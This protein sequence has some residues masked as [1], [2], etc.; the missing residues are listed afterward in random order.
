MIFLALFTC[1]IF[2]CTKDRALRVERYENGNLMTEVYYLNDSVKDG[3]AKS[4]YPNGNL[5]EEV[6][7]VNGKRQGKY[8]FYSEN[9][10]LM[11]D[12]NFQDDQGLGSSYFYNETGTLVKY[13]CTDFFNEVIYIIKW[14]SLGNK[15]LEEGL[16][17]SPNS[18]SE[19]MDDD[20]NFH[21]NRKAAIQI[22]VA[23]PPNTK[24]R[25][26]VKG[27]AVLGN[28][29]N[30]QEAIVGA[31]RATYTLNFPKKGDYYYQTVGGIVDMEGNVVRSDSIENVAHV[32]D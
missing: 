19:D 27:G 30:K 4:Y 17:F 8:L 20:G 11:E 14:D 7:F 15:T 16:A 23:E 13:R 28:G 9:G 24:T 1:T 22:I 26:W 32:V 6:S 29:Y 31:G 5:K 25:I 2:S 10:K 12:V 3:L 21:V 18:I